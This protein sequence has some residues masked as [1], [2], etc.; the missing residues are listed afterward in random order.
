MSTL[1]IKITPKTPSMTY[2]K[3]GRPR[4]YHS[5]LERKTAKKEQAREWR[6]RQRRAVTKGKVGGGLKTGIKQYLAP[7][8]PPSRPRALF[9]NEPKRRMAQAPISVGGN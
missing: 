2:P 3:P 5:D 7:K 4:K 1:R 6:L 9:A 8:R